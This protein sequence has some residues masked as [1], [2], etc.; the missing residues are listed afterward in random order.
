[1]NKFLYTLLL[2][3]LV[4]ALVA[5]FYFT[6]FPQG[7]AMWNTYQNSLHKIDDRTTYEQRKLVEDTCRS[8]IASWNAD[9]LIY[10]QYRKSDSPEKQ[11]WAEE[12]LMRA[13]KT[14]VTYNEYILKNSYVFQ[15]NI[16]DDI[17][18]VITPITD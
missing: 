13:N 3:I 2:V 7:R 17:Y 15:G 8:M 11:S 6:C 5:G 12:A 9:I 16:P 1:M 18:A 10:K 14:A 4:L